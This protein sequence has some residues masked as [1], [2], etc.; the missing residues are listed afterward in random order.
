MQVSVENTGGL[1][2]RLTVHI[3]EDEFSGKIETKLRELCKQVK[4]SGFR[5]GRVPMSVVKQRFGKQVR[6]E[7]IGD[8]V[9]TSLQQAI[10]DE[11]LR[12]ASMPR[13]ETSAE[14]MQKGDLDF[15]AVLEVYPEIEAIDVSALDL[16]RPDA[17]VEDEDIEDMLQ[18]LRDQRRTWDVVERTAEKGDRVLIEYSA[19]TEEGRFPE[20]GRDR[21]AI[22]MGESGF[23]KLEKAAAKIEPGKDKKVKLTFPEGFREASLSGKKADVELHIIS[24]S[25][26]TVPEVDEAFIQGFGIEDG[27]EETLREEIRNNLNRELANAKSTMSKTQLVK[28]L[29]KSYAGMDVPQSI[30]REE[31]SS[32]AAQMASSQGIEPNPAMADLFMP[33]AEERVRGG[34]LLGEL[35]RQNDIRIDGAKVR[36]AIENIAG[37]Y[38]QPEEVVQMYY[39][40]QR[41]LQQVESSVMED[42]VVDWVLENA[43]VTPNKMKFKDVI[44]GATEAASSFA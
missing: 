30:V 11:A 37:T 20:E 26:G 3:P 33:Q 39:N 6:Q 8:E 43:K 31:A 7:I 29:V 12:P 14:E 10:Q 34:M 36:E 19:E 32:M 15:T 13:I 35:A 1:E 27:S 9:Q 16:S 24:V 5:P 18:T 4:I 40:N 28:L 17:E 2:R 41:L 42:Q 25:E 38:Q 22:I 44:S 23:E 21:M